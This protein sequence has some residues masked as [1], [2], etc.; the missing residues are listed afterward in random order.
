MMPGRNVYTVPLNQFL[1][2]LLLS[3]FFIQFIRRDVRKSIRDNGT[4]VNVTLS[5]LNSSSSRYKQLLLYYFLVPKAIFFAEYGM[6]LLCVVLAHGPRTV[7]RL[8]AC[9]CQ[10]CEAYQYRQDVVPM[11]FF[12]CQTETPTPPPKRCKKKQ[13]QNLWCESHRKRN[14]RTPSMLLRRK[15]DSPGAYSS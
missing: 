13:K 11:S 12:E 6:I 9:L 8:R 7:K 10:D 3:C 4:V 5:Q 14:H 1:A 15:L 2:Q